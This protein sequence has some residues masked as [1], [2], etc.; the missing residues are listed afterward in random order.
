MPGV[1]QSFVPDFIRELGVARMQPRSTVDPNSA[2]RALA[3]WLHET[4]SDR[5]ESYAEFATS[6]PFQ[7]MR[8]REHTDLRQVW[9]GG[10]GEP[11]RL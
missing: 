3:T 9:T 4:D 1:L 8:P 11:S 10:S 6:E 2:R 7:A 5:R